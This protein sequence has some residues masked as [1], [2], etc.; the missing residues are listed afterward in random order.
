MGG[1]GTDPDGRRNASIRRVVVM[2]AERARW[3][4]GAGPQTEG[5][6][7]GPKTAGPGG[8]RTNGAIRMRR[9]GMLSVGALLAVGVVTGVAGDA[10]AHTPKPPVS[11]VTSVVPDHGPTDGATTVKIKGKNLITASAVVFGTTPA[12]SF[13]IQG[14]SVVATSPAETA[15]PVDV[16]VTTSDGT[17]AISSG[18]QFTYELSTPTIQNI[19]PKSGAS[20]GGT[21][22]SIVGS[23]LSGATVVNFGATPSPSFTVISP[24]VIEAVSPPGALGTVAISVTTPDGT[25]PADPADLFTYKVDA[26]KVNS[27]APDTGPNAGGNSVTITGS[28]FSKVT[29]VDFGSTPASVTIDSGKSITATAPAGS[30]VVEVTVTDA[31][32]TSAAN[33]PST[34]YTYTG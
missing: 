25:T 29:A 15:G 13:T 31:K 14:N 22:V 1:A 18:D 10:G 2:Q 21:K 30:G 6:D 4:G 28:G 9:Y 7:G 20:I 33:P 24:K 17:T 12:T 3:S 32:G 16:R 19:G 26:P 34:E 11:T 27:V 23:N 8:G 5:Q